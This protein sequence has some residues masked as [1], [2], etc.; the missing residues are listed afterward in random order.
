MKLAFARGVA[1]CAALAGACAAPN[2]KN[3]QLPA[4]SAAW[5]EPAEPIRIVGSIHYV[6]TADLGSYLITTPAG[7]I[8][9][10]GAMPPSAPLIEAS[11]RKLGFK[12]ED[13][14]LLLITHAHVDH[15]GTLAHFKRLTNANIA[16]MEGD[17]E[18]LKSGGKS[19]Y[20]FSEADSFHFEPVAV[21]R[22]LRDGDTVELGGV[23]L[24]ARHTPGHTKGCTTWITT[25]AEGDRAFSV[26]FTGST[27]INPGTRFTKDP[28]YPGIAGDY[29]H[30][31]EVQESLRPDI[32]LA[33]H[34]SAFDFVG[35]RG[36]AAAEGARAFVDPDG[37]RARIAKSKASI[38]EAIAAE[39]GAAPAASAK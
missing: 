17:V 21:D 4:N 23:S 35:K 2:T 28:S 6:G 14:K 18:L 11:I 33:A 27:S 16:A 31:I 22:V 38:E 20:L 5:Y 1:A 30:S 39:K 12:P 3:P 13:I 26:V 25:A 19:D 24:L 36:R 37:Y 15:V 10:D 7:H 8:L 32:F 29:L 9:I 34:A